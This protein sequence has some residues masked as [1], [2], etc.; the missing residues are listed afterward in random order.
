MNAGETLSDSLLIAMMLKRL[1]SEYKSFVTM[2]ISQAPENLVDFKRPLKINESI[3]KVYEQE[4]TES[5]MAVER[6]AKI[7]YYGCRQLGHIKRNCA[8]N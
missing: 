4:G 2:V 6:S 3:M 1:P 5:V 7:K 8:S